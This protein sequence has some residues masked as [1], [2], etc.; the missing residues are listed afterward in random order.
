MSL[1]KRCILLL[2][3]LAT[4]LHAQESEPPAPITKASLA[5][6]C[7][8]GTK[9]IIPDSGLLCPRPTRTFS[10]ANILHLPSV[11]Q[12]WTLLSHAEVSVT[13]ERYDATGLFGDEGWLYG[14]QGDSWSQNRVTWNGFNMTS[15]DGRRSLLLPDLNATNGMTFERMSSGA[16]L[17]LEPRKG[18]ATRHYGSGAVFFQSGA[19][20]N[21]NVSSRYREFGITDSDERYRYFTHVN[22][23]LGGPLSNYWTYF[24]SVSRAQGEKW[25]RNHTVVVPAD[26]TSETVN[27]F[28]AFPNGHRV[29]LNWIGQQASKPRDG[30]TP[31]VAD[32]STRQTSRRFQSVQ[33][34]WIANTS[35]RTLF[36][37][38]A[39][40]TIGKSDST[41]QPD[42]DGPSRQELFAGFVDIP[43]VPSAEAGKSI[44]ALLNDEWTGAAPLAESSYD[45][46]LEAKA[47][48][49]LTLDGPAASGHL[50][51]VGTN[52]EW[53]NTHDRSRA[54]E[55]IHLRFFRGAPNS[56]QLVNPADFS[57]TGTVIEGYLS[58]DIII[59]DLALSLAVK[60][61]WAHG[62]NQI[63]DSGGS[64][65]R[66]ASV[67][68]HAGV[69]YQFGNR[70]PTAFSASL[71]HRPKDAL[72]RALKA[73]HPNGSAI[74][75][76]LWNDINQ[77]GAFQPGELGALTK[78]EGSAFS[79]LD[80]RLN[81]PYA[82]EVQFEVAQRLP[83]RLTLKF[84][85]F[86]NVQHQVLALTNIGVTS[87]AYDPVPVFDPGNDGA[88]QTGD[89][90]WLTAYNQHP[91]TLGQDAYSVTN[92]PEAGAF[93]EGYEAKLSQTRSRF[94]WELEFSQYRAVA[95]AAPG[96]GPLENDWSVLAVINDPN[97]SINAYGSTF[98]DRGTGAR[99]LGTWQPGAG[100]RLS[101]LFSY[102]DGLPYGRI[103]PVSGLNQ[104][105]IG[106][107]AT[108]RGPGDGSTNNSKRAAYH[109]GA[110]LRLLREFRL[111]HGWLDAT[112]DVF[113]VFNMANQVREA[114]VT[115][116]VHLWRIPLRFQTPRSLQLGLRYSW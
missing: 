31:Q 40:L 36:D 110:D 94:R 86:R 51:A 112:L 17:A 64:A 99:F 41:F 74:S 24:G 98:F 34:L 81:Q 80:S 29:G 63:A 5:P 101:W 3:L 20:Q 107:L 2:L 55:N 18:S 84:L 79:R 30:I 96:N 52:L 105:L 42:V 25:V 19:L 11:L 43:L 53:L 88:T 48:V 115:S 77:D 39:A 21:T 104:G 57:N 33:G 14:S 8:P 26:V 89:E 91:E 54:Y 103:L 114:D 78:V 16:V 7:I 97:Q 87:S 75:T 93:A 69:R 76:H 108:R 56:V 67:G 1:A 113:N 58:D 65:I 10:S 116:P 38:R 46:R 44:V 102:M 111:S 12:P 9:E 109:L 6:L 106:I 100:L 95:R 4:P 23:Q 83:A 28:G 47:Q 59:G 49:Q 73:V 92:S 61:Q 90:A 45:R 70:Y 15:S 37:A 72:M 22:F 50:L 62:R 27:V 82:R 68:G 32:E 85:G 71:S 35:A 66:F 13:V 60:A